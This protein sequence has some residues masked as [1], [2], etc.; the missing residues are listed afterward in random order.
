M[1]I[2]LGSQEK[3]ID[4]QRLTLL[5]KRFVNKD[6]RDLV[7]LEV[8]NKDLSVKD[9]NFVITYLVSQDLEGLA[10]AAHEREDEKEEV[11][12]DKKKK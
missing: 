8:L 9:I 4:M 10:K 6:A 12:E 5:L 11:K 2:G 1:I 7:R 3:G